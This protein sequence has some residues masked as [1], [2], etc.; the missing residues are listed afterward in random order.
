METP[1]ITQ[2]KF[3]TADVEGSLLRLKEEYDELCEA[4]TPAE[5]IDEAADVVHFVEAVVASRGLSLAQVLAHMHWKR[6][7]RDAFGKDK[8]EELAHAFAL[9]AGSGLIEVSSRLG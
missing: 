8:D 4:S 6:A 5:V 2:Y 9:T 3:F 7:H 1:S